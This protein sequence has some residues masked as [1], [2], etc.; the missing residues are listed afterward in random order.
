MLSSFRLKSPSLPI[1][2][3]FVV[4]VV[5][6]APRLLYEPCPIHLHAVVISSPPTD[7]LPELSIIGIIFESPVPVPPMVAAISVEDELWSACRTTTVLLVIEAFKS[8]STTETI[9]WL[10]PLCI[11]LPEEVNVTYKLFPDPTYVGVVPAA[12]LA[13]LAAVLR[14][15]QP[16][17]RLTV[18]V[19]AA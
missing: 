11:S 6:A 16:L 10:E 12:N 5:A 19:A 18:P 1:F 17:V 8:E 15:D 7:P 13:G 9:N 2:I 4:A 14:F 3:N